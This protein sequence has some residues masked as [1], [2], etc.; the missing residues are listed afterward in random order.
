MVNGAAPDLFPRIISL[1]REKKRAPAAPWEDWDR[2]RRTQE[3]DDIVLTPLRT[4][5]FPAGS[6]DF[7]PPHA[8]LRAPPRARTPR[9]AGCSAT[10]PSRYVASIG[11]CA[12]PEAEPNSSTLPGKGRVTTIN[13]S[14]HLHRS[15][16]RLCCVDLQSGRVRPPITNTQELGRQMK[17]LLASI[18]AMTF[19]IGASY[20]EI[21]PPGPGPTVTVAPDPAKVPAPDAPGKVENETADQQIPDYVPPND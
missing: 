6:H 13:W 9:R 18:V 10:R 12:W 2:D 8:V 17:V 1:W 11:C 21:I 15:L 14:D 7:V 16:T 5:I 4:K 19:M 3:T 20:A